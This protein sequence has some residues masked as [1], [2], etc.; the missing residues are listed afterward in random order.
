MK[1]NGPSCISSHPHILGES[2]E[3]MSVPC[4][5]IGAISFS[6]STDIH[7]HVHLHVRVCARFSL[8]HSHTILHY[9]ACRQYPQYHK[10]TTGHHLQRPSSPLS[11]PNRKPSYSPP[12]Q[13]RD[14]RS[15]LPSIL[16]VHR[17]D[18]YIHKMQV[19][20]SSMCI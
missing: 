10:S 17:T 6:C 7:I 5:S 16:I 1:K 13:V 14:T 11:E 12:G 3:G 18:M 20:C 2:T 8:M 19:T 9:P 15:P 4:F